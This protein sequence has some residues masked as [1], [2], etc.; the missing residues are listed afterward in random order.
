MILY[1]E[2]EC[3]FYEGHSLKQKR[4]VM[5]RLLAK[6]RKDF[7]VAVTELDFHDLWQRTKIGIV[8][9]STNRNHTVQIIQEVLQAIDSFPE[10][11][12]TITDLEHL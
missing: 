11:E 10:L 8:T 7:N 5:K 1:A 2:V 6:L 3:M 9:I 4:S 12:R